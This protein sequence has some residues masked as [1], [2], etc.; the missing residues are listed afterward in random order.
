VDETETRDRFALLH[1]DED[2]PLTVAEDIPAGEPGGR[3]VPA[4]VPA[5]FLP[6]VF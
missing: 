2:L 6:G 5:C 1:P 4:P 3:P